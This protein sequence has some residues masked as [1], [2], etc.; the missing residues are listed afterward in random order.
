MPPSI[1]NELSHLLAIGAGA[2]LAAYTV[3]RRK[4]QHLCIPG[5]LG[6]E[7]V[8]REPTQGSQGL[9]CDGL[10][11]TQLIQSAEKL[12]GKGRR[13]KRVEGEKK[14][15][16]YKPHF[17]GGES[18]TNSGIK[19]TELDETAQREQRRLRAG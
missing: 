7:T 5:Q 6:K 13:C 11:F 17:V 1:P 12:P 8:L 2:T 15:E 18:I 3:K 19:K 9:L 14:G 4:W 10:F 16:I